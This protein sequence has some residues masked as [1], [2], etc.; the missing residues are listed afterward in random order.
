MIIKTERLIMEPLGLKHLEDYN[1]YASDYDNCK[2]MCYLPVDG[3]EESEKFLKGIEEEWANGCPNVYEFALMLGDKNIGEMGL[4]NE[5]GKAELGWVL[6]PAYQGKGY[7][8]E[9]AKALVEWGHNE[10]KYKDFIARC[11][12]ENVPSYIL[13]EKL[14]LKRVGENHDRKNRSSDEIRSEYSYEMHID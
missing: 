13:M 9:A 7:A 5:D 4:Y 12:S 14:G 8:F 10:L 3:I 6:D 11:D 2:M 1:T